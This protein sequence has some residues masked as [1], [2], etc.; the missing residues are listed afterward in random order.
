MKYK[1]LSGIWNSTDLELDKSVQINRELVKQIAYVKIKSQLYEIKW[2]GIIQIAVGIVFIK[3]L[4]GFIITNIADFRYYIPA[5]ILLIISAFSLI[6]EIY[7]MKLFY[8][9]DSKTAVIEA[10]K[11]L[12]QL[13]KLEAHDLNSLIIIIPLFSAPFLIVAAK[14]FLNIDLYA[15]NTN[16]LMLLSAG[17]ILVAAALI[18]ILRKFPN[19]KLQESIDF[20]NELKE[21]DN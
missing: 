16:W 10:Q 13:Q 8:T 12:A 7:R 2:K 19:K 3:F 11:K 21:G 6:F 9:I 15:F 14:A 18:F 17:S 5:L 4:S 20:M 1:E